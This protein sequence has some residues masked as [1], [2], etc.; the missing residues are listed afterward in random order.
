[1]LEKPAD[2]DFVAFLEILDVSA[3]TI[4]AE[5]SPLLRTVHNGDARIVI[6]V[7]KKLY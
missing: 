5:Q 1:M 3:D 4:T 7:I 6:E 2:V